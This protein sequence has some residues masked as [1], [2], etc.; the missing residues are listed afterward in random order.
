M[1]REPINENGAKD[2]RFL[3][4]QSG[5][6]IKEVMPRRAAVLVVTIPAVSASA[7][8]VSAKIML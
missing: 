5:R 7:V 1:P 6:R 2:A 4:Q 8:P 3:S